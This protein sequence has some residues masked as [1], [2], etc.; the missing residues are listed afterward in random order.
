MYAIADP[1]SRQTLRP[2]RGLIPTPDGEQ[3]YYEDMGD[4]PTLVFVHGWA[5]NTEFWSARPPTWLGRGTV[6]WLMTSA[7][8]D[9][10][11]R[12]PPGTIS[13]AW[14]MISPP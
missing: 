13:T 10:P 3:L 2:S 7:D 9:D 11:R 14:P 12:R 4:G 5:M 6:A 8:A 1:A